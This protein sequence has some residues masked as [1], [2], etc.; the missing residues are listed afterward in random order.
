MRIGLISDTHIP[1]SG[2]DIPLQVFKVFEGVDLILHAGD[3]HVIDVLDRLERIAPVLGARGNG[4]HYSSLNKHRPGVPDDPRV[5]EAH[6]L[7]LMGFTIGVTHGFP[8]PDEPPWRNNLN[9]L[10]QFNFG[11]HVEIVVCGDTHVELMVERDGVFMINPGSPTLPHNLMPQ[12]GTVGIL[13][14]QPGRRFAQII[15]LK[16]VQL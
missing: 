7:E 16:D 9:G 4:D 2:P 3:M 8:T 12:L 6:V 14:I 1:E 5:K 13:E 11:Q 10:M 15:H